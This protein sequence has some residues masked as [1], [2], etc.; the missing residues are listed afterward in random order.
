MCFDCVLHFISGAITTVAF[1]LMVRCSQRCTTR[2]SATHYSTLASFEVLGKLTMTSISGTIAE[3][4]GYNKFFALCCLVLVLNLI[5][6]RIPNRLTDNEV[7]H[8]D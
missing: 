3:K 6:L 2:I 4:I 1:T 8:C 7:T 5:V